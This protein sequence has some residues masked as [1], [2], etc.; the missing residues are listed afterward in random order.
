MLQHFPQLSCGT[1]IAV[2]YA[3]LQPC[4]ATEP[5]PGT[6]SG[7]MNGPVNGAYGPWSA[8]SQCSQT[9]QTPGLTT[10]MKERVR[11]CDDPSPSNGGLNCVNSHQGES[12]QRVSCIE[13][14][15]S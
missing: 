9:C 7:P 6:S 1:Q 2:Q 5:K 4:S 13:L 10:P 11:V 12:T 14:P 15:V 8:F 3:L